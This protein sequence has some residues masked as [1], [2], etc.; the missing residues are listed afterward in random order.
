MSC[1][2]FFRDY[3]DRFI[4][5]YE[6]P[7]TENRDHTLSPKF[8]SLISGDPKRHESKSS[9]VDEHMPSVD[10]TVSSSTP[11]VDF[12]FSGNLPS[13]ST[14]VDDGGLTFT[15]QL[16]DIAAGGDGNLQGVVSDN[17][18]RIDT[19][20]ETCQVSDTSLISLAGGDA[21]LNL[22]G[23]VGLDD[24]NL[25]PTSDILL[26]TS[27]DELGIATIVESLPIDAN[28]PVPSAD[29]SDA[30]T[31]IGKRYAFSGGRCIDFVRYRFAVKTDRSGW[32]SARSDELPWWNYQQ[33][34]L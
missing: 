5:E 28:P 15:V 8:H 26:I 7:T 34:R 22:D 11:N 29:G 23:V 1:C 16:A 32:C 27:S 20:R 17:D 6:N 19:S 30:N 12:L 18:V 14:F 2:W 3:M 33:R 21:S 9:P 25:I 31:T 24:L 10:K 13:S 4:D